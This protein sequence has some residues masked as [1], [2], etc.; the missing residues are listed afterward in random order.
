MIPIKKLFNKPAYFRRFTGLSSEQ[1]DLLYQSFSPLWEKAEEKRLDRSDRIRAIGAGREYH[2]EHHRYKLLLIL[3]FYR[4]Y[5]TTFILSLLFGF[6]QSNVSR[7]IMKLKS[8]IQ[9]AADKKLN[10]RLQSLKTT[11]TQKRKRGRNM[12]EMRRDFP[13]IAEV[14]NELLI[15]ATEQRRKRPV[16]KRK[17]KMRYSGKKK[18]HTIKT[19]IAVTPKRLIIH[20]SASVPGRIHDKTLLE[21]SALMD[22]IPKGIS[23]RLDKGYDGIQRDYPDDMIRIPI[24]RRRN[25]PKLTSSQK[26]SNTIQAKH[27]VPVEN[28][29]CDLKQNRILSYTYR[30]HEKDYHQHFMNIAALH[31]F[32]LLH[33][34]SP[35]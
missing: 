5:P 8:I 27:R 28:T 20:V 2:L 4:S 18:A 30:H 3:C 31:N 19:Q 1:F 16:H 11:F 29:F 7:L 26:R 12:E 23:K 34:I 35:S 25:S 17:Q 9:T 14:I 6:D 22:K 13:N 21:Q 15:D 10:R 32:K 33:P 24:K